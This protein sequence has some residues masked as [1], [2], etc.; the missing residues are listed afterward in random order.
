MLPALNIEKKRTCIPYINNPLNTNNNEK[1][2]LID[3]LKKIGVSLK[4]TPIKS[5]SLRIHRSDP[6]E[7]WCTC[8]F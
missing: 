5:F 8:L 6:D 3:D 2:K 7:L 4:N 1:H